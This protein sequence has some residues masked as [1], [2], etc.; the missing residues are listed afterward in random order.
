MTAPGLTVQKIGIAAGQF[1]QAGAGSAPCELARVTGGR[2]CRA[3]PGSVPQHGC[4]DPLLTVIVTVEP[5]ATTVPAIGVWPITSPGSVHCRVWAI[6]VASPRA[7][8]SLVARP[9]VRDS[10]SGTATPPAEMVTST[11]DEEGSIVPAG[12]F[13]A[14]TVPALARLTTEV[15]LPVMRCERDRRRSTELWS[16]PVRSG[17]MVAGA[18]ERTITAAWV[19]ERYPGWEPSSI[20][21]GLPAIQETT[22]CRMKLRDPPHRAEMGTVM[23]EP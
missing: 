5:G 12:E 1:S 3:Q 18:V 11:I 23:G 17:T 16:A 19:A 7:A 20:L 9:W 14:M 13:S 8:S 22:A 10:S 21:T 4:R 6:R 15:T 2:T